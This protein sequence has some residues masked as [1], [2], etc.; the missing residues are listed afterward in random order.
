MNT[1]QIH[2]AARPKAL[3]GLMTSVSIMLATGCATLPQDAGFKDVQET[4][5]KRTGERIEW[6]RGTDEVAAAQAAVQELLSAEL[7][8]D[9]AV[10]IA[11][12]NNRGLQA[13]YQNLN[14]GQANLVQA[15]LLTNPVFN[16]AIG[17]PIDGG[18][19]DLNFNIVQDFLSILYRPLRKRIA[20]AQ[21]DAAKRRVAGAAIDLAA[22]TRTAFYELQADQQRFE[23]LQQVVKSTAASAEAAQRLYDAG[24]ITN[25]DLAREQAIYH[26]SRL[27]LSTAEIRL[28]QGR[29]RLNALM[30]LWGKNTQW[31]IARRL[32]EIPNQPLKLADLETRAIAASLSLGAARKEIQGAAGV[33]GFTNTS[34][35]VPF[36]APGLDAE[37]REGEWELGPTFSLP[38][39]IFNQGQ[40]RIAA[41]RSDLRRAQQLYWAQAV[42]IR[43]AVR[44]ARASVLSAR[45]RALHVRTVLLPLATQILN[46]TQLQFNAMQLGVFQLLL[47]KVQQI[48]A[49][50]R[51]IDT[52]NDYWRAHTMLEQI[53]DGGQVGGIE[54]TP[55]AEIAGGAVPTISLPE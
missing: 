23:F 37:R 21:F 3:I 33:L 46:D 54:T 13:I 53:L 1:A 9:E 48:D 10:Q 18:L 15:G 20:A 5:A 38:L 22:Q 32:P 17:F 45:S 41:A 43:A 16:A 35:L 8:V 11:L 39:P 28:I 55:M 30:G 40:A 26:Q 24:N 42:Q 31:S 50:L 27:A 4:M 2:S 29:E 14:L 47:A 6:N 51:Y 25:L 12:L 7:N 44:A 19:L 36:V 52:L 34:A 49:G